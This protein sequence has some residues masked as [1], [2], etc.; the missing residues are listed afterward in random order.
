MSRKPEFIT[1]F[2]EAAHGAKPRGQGSWAFIAADGTDVADRYGLVADAY[3]PYAAAKT[4][5]VRRLTT[6]NGRKPAYV[7]TLS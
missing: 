3:G 7:H 5:A 6:A 2:F 1:R 4:M